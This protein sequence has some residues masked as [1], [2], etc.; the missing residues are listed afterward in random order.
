[1][2]WNLDLKK[3]LNISN[4]YKN[5]KNKNELKKMIKNIKIFL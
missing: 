4:L 5:N 3:R 2:N 1:M